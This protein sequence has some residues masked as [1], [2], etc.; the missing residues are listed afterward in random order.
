LVF[1][2]YNDI[3]G[4]NLLPTVHPRYTKRGLRAATLNFHDFR[5]NAYLP[6][7]QPFYGRSSFC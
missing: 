4:G 5:D 7:I 1:P 3:S 2:R 6:G